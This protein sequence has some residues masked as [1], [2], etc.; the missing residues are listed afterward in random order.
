MIRVV[1]TGLGYSEG[2]I[3]SGKINGT[4]GSA[5]VDC[6][7]GFRFDGTTLS[8]TCANGVSRTTLDLSVTLSETHNGQLGYL[9]EAVLTP[10]SNV[11]FFVDGTSKGTINTNLPGSHASHTQDYAYYMISFGL[12]SQAGLDDTGGLG[13]EWSEYTVL[14]DQ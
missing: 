9:L 3:V 4:L 11:E 10:G 5:N 8:G 2:E 6:H 1:W 13:Y 14:Q 12:A 7:F